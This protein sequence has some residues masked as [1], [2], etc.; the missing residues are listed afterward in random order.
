MLDSSVVVAWIVGDEPWTLRALEMAS[1]IAAGAVEAIVAPNL[2][3]EVRGALV[4]SARR[5]RVSWGD[6]L[7]RLASLDAMSLVNA[8]INMPDSDLLRLC[9]DYRLGWGDAQHALVAE[10]LRLPLVTADDRL[11]RALA[12]SGIWVESIASRPLTTI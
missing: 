9:R 12:G 1:D 10:R 5:G 2:H 6:V 4:R 8:R 11:V 3:F 7:P